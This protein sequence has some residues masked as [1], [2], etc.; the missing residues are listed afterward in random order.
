MH[1]FGIFCFVVIN[2]LKIA[3]MVFIGKGI[4]EKN[5]AVQLR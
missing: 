4:S 2:L 5:K 3:L 1:G